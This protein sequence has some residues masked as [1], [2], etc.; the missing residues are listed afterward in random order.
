MKQIYP[1]MLGLSLALSAC[2]T[3]Q[4]PADLCLLVGTYTDAG[5]YG[6]YSYR[7]QP[8]DGS[9][10]LLDSLQM[11]NPSFLLPVPDCPQRVYAVSETPDSTASLCLLSLNPA[12]GRI[13]LLD[14]QATQGADPCQIAAWGE[15]V[16]TAN[17]SG[18]SLT[19]LHTDADRLKLRRDTL[20]L[21]QTGGNDTL[22][23][24]TPHLHGALFTAD[25]RH[26]F[27]TDFSSDR[28]L[29]CNVSPTGIHAPQTAI[30]LE[31]GTG[32]HHLCFSSDERFLYVLGELNGKISVMR[33]TDGRLK[34]I[35][36]LLADTLGA[37]GSADIHLSPDGRHLYASHRLQGDGLSI[38]EVDPT[39]GTLTRI[40]FQPTG[41]HPRN[42]GL[43]PD[44]TLLLVAC[45]DSRIIELYRRQP[46]SGLLTHCGP[47]I[48][49][50]KPVCVQFVKP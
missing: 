32:P 8:Q 45:R 1:F 43:T 38:Y 26:L 21:G 22:R 2:Q 40:G 28:L 7:L 30:Q 16:T 9:S 50:S 25:G 5:S 3:P 20:Y 42:F 46:E 44:G 11:V 36:T 39:E 49:L 14:C 15:L 12:T 31:A 47:D 10:V 13:S 27:A 6:I 48:R 37:R 24:A 4:T 41:R 33:H 17:Y 35:Q 29:H 19:C 34:E 23:Q 18:G